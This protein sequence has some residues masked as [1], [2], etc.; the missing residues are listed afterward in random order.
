MALPEKPS[1]AVLPFANMSGEQGQEYFAD[2]IAEDLITA[3]SRFHWFFVIARNSSFSYKGASPDVRDV[4]RDLGV[5][6]VLEGSVRKAADRVRITAQLIDALTGHHIWAERYDRELDDIFAVQDEI[7]EAIAS[8]V[9]P[10]FV[11]AEERRVDRKAPE[12][13]DAW[14]H[15]VRGNWHLWRLAREDVAE[16]GRQFQTA[17]TLDAGSVAALSGLANTRGMESYY[18]WSNDPQSSFDEAYKSAKAAVEADQGDAGAHCALAFIDFWTKRHDAAIA[19]CERALA[20]NPNLAL[21]ESILGGIYSWTGDYENSI[22]HTE[23]AERLSPRDPALSLWGINRA[24]AE[25]CRAQYDVAAALARKAI[26]AAPDHPS[27][28]RM[29]ASSVPLAT[30]DSQQAYLMRIC[31]HGQESEDPAGARGSG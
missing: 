2:G 13:F 14:D 15:V 7:T 20:L 23:N 28:W 10:S 27:A 6:Y 31:R 22:R 21:A 1:I 9:A 17:I 16:A 25:F 24:T 3:L 4:A 18:G 11:S 19:S 29:L 26:E 30:N 5:Q 8:A 12:S